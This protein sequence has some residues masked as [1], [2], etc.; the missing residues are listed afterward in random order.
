MTARKTPPIDLGIYAD[1]LRD[2]ITLVKPFIGTDD[3]LPVLRGYQLE[4]HGGD[5]Y[6]LGTDRYTLAVARIEPIDEQKFPAR[7]VAFI[8]ATLAIRALLLFKRGR[9][10]PPLPLTISAHGQWTAIENVPRDDEPPTRLVGAA[11]D[12]FPA[13]RSMLLGAIRD[14]QKSQKADPA[15]AVPAVGFDPEFLA[16]FAIVKKVLGSYAPTVWRTQGRN[17]PLI[18][19]A[20]HEFFGMQ[21]PVRLA[22]GQGDELDAWAERFTDPEPSAVKRARKAP[23]KKAAPKPATKLRRKSA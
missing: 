12:G 7:F 18:V 3:T 1:Q 4:V 16:R 23:A 19:T 5:L 10:M 8:P 21:M 15:E 20:G 13:T 9:G 17:R 2:A 6:V 14:W 11:Q 22:N